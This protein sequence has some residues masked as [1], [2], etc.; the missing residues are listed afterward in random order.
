[1]EG[2]VRT[3]VVLVVDVLEN[4]VT[5][6]HFRR[7]GPLDG[8]HPHIV[9]I[10]PV[11]S[12]QLLLDGAKTEIPKPFIVESGQ[13]PLQKL[14]TIR[15]PTRH[16]FR[17]VERW[18]GLVV[19]DVVR[20]INLSHRCELRHLVVMVVSEENQTGRVLVGFS[21]RLILSKLMRYS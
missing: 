18:S 16:P 14:S 5:I 3:V 8:D 21:N 6:L 4:H 9:P 17:K 13:N 7:V 19:V 12:I 20:E 11:G 1:M 10:D 2:D 15:P